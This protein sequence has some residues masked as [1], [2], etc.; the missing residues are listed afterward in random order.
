MSKMKGMRWW[1]VGMVTL[2]LI[3][4]YLARN[5]LS[6]A[7]PTMM[8][9]LGVSTKEYSY[10]VVA[11]QVCYAMMQPIAGFV[12]DAIGTKIGFA[13]FA[14][15]WSVACASAA[16]ASGWQ[17]MAFFRG[18]L[19]LTEAAGIPAG[20]KATTEWFPA[21]ERS[22]AIGWFNIGS[23]IGA[24]CAP[25]LVVWTILHASWQWSFVVV[26]VLGIAWTLLW[27]LFY[28]HPRDQ[29]RLSNVEREYILAGQEE[30]YKE[31]AA[32]LPKVSWKQIVRSRNFYSIAI[33]RFLS[34]PAW[35]TF[36]AWIPLYMAT[37]RHMN[38][39]EIAMFAWLPFLA[40]DIGC[41]LGGYMSPFFHKHFKVS[42][43]N[44][45][46]WVMAVGSLSMIAPG[47]I[48]LVESPYTAI[49]LL[50]VG[51]FAHQT[52]SGAL[53]AITSDVFGKNEVATATGLAGM[54]GY[55]GATLFTL[56][57]GVLVTVVGYSPL[58]VVLAVFD[59]LACIVVWT[60]VR[61]SAPGPKLP[62][63][64]KV[65]ASQS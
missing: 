40:A 43:F 4:N 60:L 54:S 49:A 13:V 8:Q 17:S 7:A 6:V 58:F 44:S 65:A 20:V 14:L 27:V 46:K 62:M 22:V 21:R 30:K 12:L 36:N 16:L 59:V 56:V 64:P 2:G 48:G 5:T 29:K 18:L 42:L 55:L 63:A 53:Y 3:V 38:I 19:G 33:P 26:G 39:K 24:L 9:D 35:Q 1:M 45:R 15:A 32:T 50:C 47:C 61:E 51:G 41:V 52:L 57:F 23:S 28:K 37:E 11:W 10:I 31:G 34:E 25:P